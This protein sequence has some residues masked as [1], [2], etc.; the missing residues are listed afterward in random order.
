[1]A[2]KSRILINNFFFRAYNNNVE[3]ITI[4]QDGYDSLYMSYIY[5]RVRE[6]FSFLPAMC[7]LRR[8]GARAEIVFGTEN[9]Y[10][11]YVRRFAEE[12]IADVIA[13]GYKYAYFE[14]CLP[15]PF[16]SAL[17][18]RLLITALVAA[19]YREDRNY[20]LRRLRGQQT[21]CLDGVYH[22]RLRELK[23]RWEGISEYVPTN[24][25]ETSLDG[26]LEFLTEDGEGKLFLKDGKTY[27]EDYRRLSKSLLTGVESPVGEILLGGAKQ[28]YCF[29][30]VDGETKAFLKK[31]YGINAVFC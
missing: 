16:L 3:E 24:L 14:N 26:F 29:G 18:K 10:C 9:S 4:T 13:V 8:D 28:V 6:R 20:V 12:N 22:F 31:Y 15:L 11:P 19:D 27:G 2:R 17:Q 7:E 1:M 23:K 30:E 5:G 21:Y 25:D